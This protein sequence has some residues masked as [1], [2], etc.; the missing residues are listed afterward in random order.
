MAISRTTELEAVNTMLSAVGEP[1]INYLDGQKNAD[2]AISRNILTEISR[3]VQ[4]QGWHFNTQRNVTLSPGVDT[5]ITLSDNVVRVDIEYWTSQGSSTSRDSRD[6]TQRGNRL[7]NRT[8]NTYAFTTDVKASVVYLF[9][10]EELPEPARRYVVVKAARIFQDRMVGSQAHHAF[11]Q[12][13]EARARASL[14]EF[15]TD[16]SDPTIFGNYDVFNIIDRPSTGI[17]RS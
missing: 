8:D 7:F 14:K 5:F 10:W 15:E 11:S 1:P 3:D 16:T 13:D 2:A 9:D 12:E 17:G 6:I 4:M